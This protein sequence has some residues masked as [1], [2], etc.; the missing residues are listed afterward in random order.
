MNRLLLVIAGVF[1][2]FCSCEEKPFYEDTKQV[3]GES[4]SYDVPVSFEVV[5]EDT[6]MMYDMHLDIDHA[7][8]FSYQ[9]LYLNVTTSFP[10]KEDKVERLNI[11]LAEN[12]GKWIGN[13]N[14]EKCKLKVYMLDGFK[15]A[16]A[17]TYTFSFEQF[18]REENLSGIYAL[19]LKIYPNES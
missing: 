2:L 19:G 11:N 7:P 9:N 4:W 13:C 1:I 15:F 6:T 14:K 17:G 12:N 3:N 18:S 5:V 10:K 8:D 16:D